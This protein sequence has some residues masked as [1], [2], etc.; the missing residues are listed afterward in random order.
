MTA[1]WSG[2]KPGRTG[3]RSAGG[4][5]EDER[6]GFDRTFFSRP[7]AKGRGRPTFPQIAIVEPAL[8]AG[9]RSRRLRGLKFGIGLMRVP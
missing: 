2:G 1:S 6:F 9:E 4:T 8:G 3:V 5:R 7:F